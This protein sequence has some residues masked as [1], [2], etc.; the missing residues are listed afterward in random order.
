MTP[1]SHPAIA[2]TSPATLYAL[3]APIICAGLAAIVYGAIFTFLALRQTAGTEAQNGRAF[4]LSSAFV[5][6]ATLCVVLVASAFLQ[7][8]FGAK[9]VVFAAAIPKRLRHMPLVRVG[10]PVV[11]FPGCEMELVPHPPEQVERLHAH[12]VEASGAVGSEQVAQVA[13][14]ELG[15]VRLEG[16]PWG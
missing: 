14:G 1:A 8:Q 16:L 6:A 13:A 3:A 15:G 10:E 9:G 7:D 5:F 11:L 4:S 12:G 2:A